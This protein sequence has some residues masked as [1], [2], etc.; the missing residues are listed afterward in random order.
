MRKLMLRSA[1][2]L[3]ERTLKTGGT[4][5]HL[6]EC[7][8]KPPT[9]KCADFGGRY[10]QNRRNV[11]SPGGLA[12]I[13]EECTLKTGGTSAHL[14]EC[15]LK[16]PTEECRFRRNVQSKPEERPLTWRSVRSNR[17]LKCADFGGMYAQNRRNVRSPGGVVPISEECTVKTGGTSAHLED[18]TLKPP[19]EVRRFRRNVRSKPEERPLTWRSVRSNRR[20]K[21]ADFG[22]MYSQNRRNVRSPGGVAP[23]PEECT[24]KTG[25]TSAH[26]EDCTLKP[27]PEVRRFR[28]NVRSKPEERPLTWRSVRSNRRLRSAPILEECTLKTGGTSAHLEECTLKPPTEVCR[29][30]RNVQ[31]K[32]EERPLTWRSECTLKTGGTSAHLEDCT[33]KP[34]PEVRRFRRNVRSKPEERPLTWR[35][36]RSNRRLKSADFGGMYSQNRRNVRSPGGLAPISE[37]CTLKTGGTSAHLEDC[38]LKPPTEKCADFGGMYSQNRRNVRSPGGVAPIPEE[39]TLKTGGTSAHLED[40][41]LKPPPEVRRFWRNVR[42][43]PEERP[44]TWRSVRSNRRLRSAPILEECTLKTRGTSAH[45][46]ECTLKPPTEVCRFWRN[47]Q[48]KPEERPLTWRSECTLKTGGTSAHL[49]E[50]TLKPP[51]EVRRFR[52]NVRSKPEERP[53]TWRTVRS[54]RR[55]KCADFGGMYAQNRRNVRSPGGVYAQTAAVRSAPISEERTLNG[56]WAVMRRFNISRGIINSIEALYKG[57]QST[58]MTGDEFSECFPTSVGVRQGCLLSPTLC[59]IFLENIMREALSPQESPV[60]LAGR[61]INH[62]Q[63]ADDVDLLDGSKQDQQAH[64][65]SLDSTSRRYG[66]EV[67]LEKTKC[68]Y[69]RHIAP[70]PCTTESRPIFGRTSHECRPFFVFNNRAMV[71]EYGRPSRELREI[72]GR[73]SSVPRPTCAKFLKSCVLRAIFVPVSGEGSTSLGRAPLVDNVTGVI[74]TGPP[75]TVQVT[76]RGTDLEQVNEFSYLGSLQTAD[77]SSSREVKIRIAKSTSVLGKLKHIWASSNISTK[78]KIYLL[79]SLVLSIFLYGAEAWTLNAEITKRINA[80]EMNCYRRLLQI[81]WSTHTTNEEV[82][83]RVKSLAGPLPSFLSLVKKRKLQWFGHVTRAKGTLAHTTLQGKAEGGRMRGRPRRTWTSDLKEW[84]GHPLSHL[85]SLAE[86]RP[87]WITLVDSLVAPTAGQTA[88]GPVRSVRSNRRREKCADF[89]GMYA[90]NRRNVRSPGIVYAQTA[91]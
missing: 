50:C 10:A 46:E 30:W 68:L 6:E 9:E 91:D 7:T 8:L 87:G 70:R 57:S 55:L 85:T 81:H 38:T 17:R 32:P 62:L 58:V 69:P 82:K 80:F 42:S 52:R 31:S 54:N 20:L 26:L 84:T 77:C 23:I 47:V 5:A 60:K 74:V 72:F 19:P 64:F 44:L 27:P 37:E 41:T 29:F 13:S 18:C 36:V 71:A 86:N 28:R 25:G 12:P 75:D 39:C 4:S 56:L 1:P 59:N 43:K 89:G 21:C 24:L 35:S 48:S 53:L 33:L 67:S 66:M 65:S 34:P 61:I 11:R 3:E 73:P 14:E 90:Q 83:H 40:C 88:M 16:P 51:P 79:R 22:G 45:L 63:F 78:T 76:V 49:E 15:T 2:I